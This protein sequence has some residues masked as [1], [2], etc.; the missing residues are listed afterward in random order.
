MSSKLLF[1]VFAISFISFYGFSQCP[2]I[3][4]EYRTTHYPDTEYYVGYFSIIN[5]NQNLAECIQKANLGAQAQLVTSISNEVSSN[6]KSTIAAVN[7]NG[8]Y[9]EEETFL[10]EFISSASAHL[11]NIHTEYYHDKG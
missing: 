5:N 2:W 9:S 11:I 8:N 10:N 6:S 4:M 1:I 7:S 3:D